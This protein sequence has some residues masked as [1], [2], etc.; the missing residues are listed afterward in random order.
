MNMILLQLWVHIMQFWQRKVFCIIWSCS[1]HN[2]I[3][4]YMIYLLLKHHVN[5][6][7]LPFTTTITAKRKYILVVP[8]FGCS[9]NN[10]VILLSLEITLR[11]VSRQQGWSI[12]TVQ[13]TNM[14]NSLNIQRFHVFTPTTIFV[15]QDISL[16]VCH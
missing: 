4:Y 2:F 16:N 8:S 15:I 13:K 9:N 1:N 3:H 14:M 12:S 7:L 5:A 10:V 6:P 11:G